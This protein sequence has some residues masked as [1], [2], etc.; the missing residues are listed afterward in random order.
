[1]A[2]RG[3]DELLLAGQLELDR[4]AGPQRRQHDHVLDQHLLLAA[5]A[6]AHALGEYVDIAREETE[7]VAELLLGDKGGLRAGPHVQSPVV[8]LP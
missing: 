5:E 2:R 3:G 6:A 4:T 7:E 8:A 1:M